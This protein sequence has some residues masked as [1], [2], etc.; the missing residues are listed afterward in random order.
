M[1]INDIVILRFYNSLLKPQ[2]KEFRKLVEKNG[3]KEQTFRNWLYYERIPDD[4]SV[5]VL[6]KIIRDN[7]F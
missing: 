6:R 4:K 5:S 3:I 1:K 2:Q 7:F